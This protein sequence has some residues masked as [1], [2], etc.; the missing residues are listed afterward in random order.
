[1]AY[2]KESYLTEVET[3][4]VGNSRWDYEL[5]D[6]DVEWIKEQERKL[7]EQVE[8]TSETISRERD[9]LEGGGDEQE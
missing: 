7:D 3:Y 8:R 4:G 6:N 5:Q 9:S 2:M 1:M